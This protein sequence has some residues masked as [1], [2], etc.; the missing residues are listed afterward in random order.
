MSYETEKDLSNIS[1]S[2]IRIIFLLL[3]IIINRGV[4]LKI[5]FLTNTVDILD[6]PRP[7]KGMEL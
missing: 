2:I 1:V 5:M 6:C 4:S 7:H 3:K